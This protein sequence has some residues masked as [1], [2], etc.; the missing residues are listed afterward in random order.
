MDGARGFELVKGLVDAELASRFVAETLAGQGRRTCS[1]R[2]HPCPARHTWQEFAVHDES[3]AARWSASPG[4]LSF[5]SDAGDPDPGREPRR[6]CWMNV[7]DPGESIDPHRDADG[8]IQLVVALS[9]VACGGEIHLRDGARVTSLGLGLGDALL[10]DATQIEHWTSPA[11]SERRIT[12]VARCPSP[13]SSAHHTTSRAARGRCS[14]SSR[15]TVPCLRC[16]RCCAQ[17]SP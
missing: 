8:A 1:G 4:V 9:S 16:R 11:P 14:G 15:C 7:F 5:V 17:A 12:L 3:A 2:L 10:F 6:R 13:R